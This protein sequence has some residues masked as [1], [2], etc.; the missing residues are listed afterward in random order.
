MNTVK[1]ERQLKPCPFCGG[2][3]KFGIS[4]SDKKQCWYTKVHCTFCQA[5][6]D[7]R[8]SIE[9]PEW[10]ITEVAALWNARAKE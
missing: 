2:K 10:E 5:K 3:A 9:S 4:Y 8:K 6:S 7:S 1:L